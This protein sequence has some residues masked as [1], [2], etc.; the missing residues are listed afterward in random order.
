MTQEVKFKLKGSKPDQAFIE[1]NERMSKNFDQDGYYE[2][3]HPFIVWVEKLRLKTICKLIKG[4]I[5]KN[6]LNNPIILEVGCGAGHVL[7]EIQ[8]EVKTNNLIGLDP[9]EDWLSIA[10]KKVGSEVNLIKGFAEDLPFKDNSMDIVVCTEVIEHIIDPTVVLK[11]LK[12]VVKSDGPIIVSIPNEKLINTLKEIIDFFKLY[13]I[14]FSNIVKHND[15]HIHH[16]DLALFREKLPDNLKINSINQVPT[17]F[18]PL[19]YVMTLK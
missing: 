9:L 10:R 11:E 14:F 8:N 16:F 5:K 3:S 12:R 13:K 15:W 19:R 2:K 17:F 18:L 6:N 4:E 7:K 1:W